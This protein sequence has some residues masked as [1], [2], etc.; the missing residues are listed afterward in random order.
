LLDISKIIS[1]HC[2]ITTHCNAR[3]PQ[4]PRNF[5]GWNQP[6]NVELKHMKPLELRKITDQLPPVYALFCGNHGDPMMHPDPMGLA[7]QFKHV[8]I[9]T[10]GSMGALKTYRQLAEN[11]VDIWFSIDGLED[12]NHIYRQDVVWDNIMERVDAFISAGGCATWKF[13][14]FRHNMHQIDRAREL[15]A[16]LGFSNFHLVRAGRDWGPILNNTGE[17]IG[18]LLPADRDVQPYEYDRDFEIELRTNPINLHNDRS[19]A[20]I[21]CEMLRDGTIY[22]DVDCNILP[23]CYH[24]V[25]THIQAQGNTLQEQLNSFAFLQDNWGK[26]DCDETCYSA[27]K[28]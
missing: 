22:V 18:W 10:N 14:V 27:C 9:N 24:G 16:E 4:C 21:D 17:E 11:G 8:T 15:S 3:C 5:C 6:V 26:K 13:V 25:N 2:E 1:L 28:R 19:N 7:Y 12:T 20:I 23:C